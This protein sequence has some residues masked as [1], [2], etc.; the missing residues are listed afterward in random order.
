MKLDNDFHILNSPIHSI[1][2]SKEF[3]S[4]AIDNEYQTLQQ[5]LDIP[6]TQLVRMNWFTPTM[7]SELASFVKNRSIKSA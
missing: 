3:V 6:L 7:F 5:L 2:L 1:G 4:A